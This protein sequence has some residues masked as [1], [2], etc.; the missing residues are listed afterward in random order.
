MMRTRLVI[1][2][3]IIVACFAG[4][5]SV[6]AAEAVNAV[7]AV[8]A[9]EA[10]TTASENALDSAQP[11]HLTLDDAIALALEC[12]PSVLSA[13]N[14]VYS[15]EAALKKELAAF[16]P[17][18]TI[19]VNYGRTP[20][21]AAAGEERTYQQ[22]ANITIRISQEISGIIPRFIGWRTVNAIETATWNLADAQ[23]ALIQAQNSAIISV[24]QKYL[25]VLKAEKV[26]ELNNSAYKMAEDDARVVSINLEEGIATRMDLMRAQSA[27]EKARIDRINAEASWQIAVDSLLMQI[28]YDFGTPVAL[29]PVTDINVEVPGSGVIAEMTEQA[30]QNRSDILSVRTRLKKAESDVAQAKNSFLPSLKLSAS[31]RWG[32]FVIGITLDPI[33]ASIQW[34]VDGIIWQKNEPAMSAADGLT[35]KLDFVWN[36]LDAIERAA[37]LKSAQA[38]LDSAR[39]A[40]KRA[41]DNLRLEIRQKLNDFETARLRLEQARREYSIAQESRAL[42]ALRYQEGVALFSE[43]AQA[44][45]SLA[46]SD[47]SVAQ[48]EYELLMAS[49][50]L[51]NACGLSPRTK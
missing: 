14:S 19:S 13:R 10:V 16:I 23:A 45:Q 3:M 41:E 28:G 7:T 49:I 4:A 48:A 51:Y 6:A 30:L 50:N 33:N 22:D 5:V 9:V 20:D 40:L 17:S 43:L 15:S 2:L 18:A 38:N 47:Y 26:L 11:L 12:D 42:A 44:A 29:E 31:Q 39:I 32:D 35:L 24:M 1:I 34:N 25:A 8:K 37:M 36:P 46:Q 27:L 21:K